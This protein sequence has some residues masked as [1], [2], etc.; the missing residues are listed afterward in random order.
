MKK[1][2]NR[3]NCYKTTKAQLFYGSTMTERG[4]SMAEDDFQ[5]KWL[6]LCSLLRAVVRQAKRDLRKTGYRR[7]AYLFLTSLVTD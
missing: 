2:S 1:G 7:E 5:A 3:Y 6:G 4:F